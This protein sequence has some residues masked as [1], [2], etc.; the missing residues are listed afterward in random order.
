MQYNARMHRLT[1]KSF[2]K[3]LKMTS[4]RQ[5]SATR[6]ALYRHLVLGYSLKDSYEGAGIGQSTMSAAM[7]RVAE[8]DIDARDY[9]DS[10]EPK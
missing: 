5:G 6:D 4:V 2:E 1:E 8:A 7:S 10:L 9:V 3:L